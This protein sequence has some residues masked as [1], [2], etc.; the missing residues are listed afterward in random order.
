LIYPRSEFATD[1]E[2][3]IRNSDI[4]IRRF[5]IDLAVPSDVLI[6]EARNL[7][8]RVVEWIADC[9]GQQQSA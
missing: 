2:I 6:T 7:V 1:D 3:L 5:A 9:E 4:R 8:T